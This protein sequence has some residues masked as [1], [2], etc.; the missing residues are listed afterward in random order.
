MKSQQQVGVQSSEMALCTA[1][2][3]VTSPCPDHSCPPALRST[4]SLSFNQHHLRALEVFPLPPVL[5]LP[6]ECDRQMHSHV[7]GVHSSPFVQPM[8][9]AVGTVLR[10]KYSPHRQTQL[11]LIGKHTSAGT[12]GSSEKAEAQGFPPP[13][14]VTLETAQPCCASTPPHHMVSN[15]RSSLVPKNLMEMKSSVPLSSAQVPRAGYTS[16]KKSHV[17]KFPLLN[18]IFIVH[19]FGGKVPQLNFT[20][21]KSKRDLRWRGLCSTQ[22]VWTAVKTRYPDKKTPRVQGWKPGH[23]DGVLWQHRSQ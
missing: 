2:H 20:R 11:T 5:P 21:T 14:C 23:P 12:Q 19:F 16:A 13:C 10:A 3:H 6:H 4:A 22:F 15:T 8:H 17:C 18:C 9:T 7:P 1:S